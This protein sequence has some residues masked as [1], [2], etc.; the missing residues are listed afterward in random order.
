MKVQ[1]SCGN[2]TSNK[3]QL[4]IL[5]IKYPRSLEIDAVGGIKYSC[6]EVLF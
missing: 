4:A 1:E 6:R 5:S 2:P 3:F